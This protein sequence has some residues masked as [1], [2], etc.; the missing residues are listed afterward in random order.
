MLL[1]Y[2]ESIFVDFI[3][4]GLK[5]HTIRRDKCKRWKLGMSIQHWRGNPRNTKSNPYHFLDGQCMGVEEIEILRVSEKLFAV[6]IGPENSSGKR[7]LTNDEVLQL[8]KNDGLTLGQF[9]R[10]FLP[11]GVDKWTGRIIHFTDFKY[12]KP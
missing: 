5:I 10:W 7:V 3:K 8:A 2:R 4:Q 11:D 6:S 9:R 1:T 12:C